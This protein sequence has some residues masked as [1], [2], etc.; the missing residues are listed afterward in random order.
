ML[1]R[2][3]LRGTLICRAPDD[4]EFAPD[5]ILAL[6]QLAYRLATDRDDILAASLRTE[7]NALRLQR[8]GLQASQTVH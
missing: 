5:E 8:V 7:L 3:Q 6:E 1:V 4:G 2:G